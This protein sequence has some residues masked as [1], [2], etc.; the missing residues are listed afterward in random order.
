MRQSFLTKIG[1]LAAFAAISLTAAPL[2]AEPKH[3]IAMYGEPALGQD[4]I[5]LPYANPNAPKGGKIVT[6]ETGSFDSLNP[7]IRKGS[8]PW[9]LRFLAYESLMGRSYDE[10]FTLYGLLAESIETGP[11]RE[12]VEFTL[13]PEARFSDGSPVT[14]E[15]VMWSYETLGTQGHPRYA[16]AWTKVGAME[17]TGPRKIKFTFNTEDREM[18]LIIGMRPILKKAQWEGIDFTESGL[19]N[20]P[21]SSAPYVIADFEAGRFVSLKRNP[22]YWGNDLPFR[23]GTNNFDE[24][25]MEFFADGTAAFEA[26]KA[27]VANTS[28][29]FNQQKWDTQYDFPAIDSGDVIKAILPHQR[30]TG[31]TG[32]VMN[33]RRALLDD[34]RVRDALIHAFNFEFINQTQ[35]GGK[36]TRI[37]SYF[38]NSVLGMR[39]GPA[40]GKVRALLTPFE[41]EL[42]PGALDG[43][44]LPAGDGSERNRANIRKAT[45]I[46]A[47]AGWT[48][49]DQGVLRNQAGEAFEFEVLL[50]QGSAENKAIIDIYTKSLERLGITANVTV[51]DPAQYKQ[52]TDIYDFDMTYYRRGLSLSPG[53]EQKLYW[54][55]EGVEAPGTRNWMGMNSPAAEAMIDKILN[56]QSRD[57]FIAATRALDRILTSGRYVIPIY[58]FNISRVAH[59]KEL[60]YPENLPIYGDWIGWQPDVWWYE[61]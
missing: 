49:D 40:E 58:A 22:D 9:Q 11:N 12:W 47:E 32:F 45:A 14:V 57:D 7:H 26:F 31:I 28:R 1:T 60:R 46:L 3:G 20:I 24:I 44:A 34:W 36:Q 55:A 61:E 43:Y 33:T 23:R 59:A 10:P 30:P 2:K 37:T 15:D 52:R 17:Q 6:A 39:D 50:R 13:R 56:S 38:S 5:A 29:E 51:I 42:L 53:N 19:E 35:T 41:A 8:V 21:V 4:F 48:V 16:G 25:R 54:G 18:A 27:G